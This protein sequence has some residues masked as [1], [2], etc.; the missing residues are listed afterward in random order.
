MGVPAIPYNSLKFGYFRLLEKRNLRKGDIRAFVGLRTWYNERERLEAGEN[1][2]AAHI[3]AFEEALS[4]TKEAIKENN[5]HERLDRDLKRWAREGGMLLRK[6]GGQTL[7]PPPIPEMKKWRGNGLTSISLFS[8]AFGLDLGFLAAGFDL[9]LANDI[10]INSYNTVTGN[11]GSIPFIHEDFT[12]VKIK[13]ALEIA[14]LD[15]GE[16][17]VLTGGPPCQ[18]FSTAGKREGLN[19]PRASPLKAFARAIKQIRPRA[20]V[21][22]EV[23]GLKSARLRHVPIKERKGRILTTEEQKG[24]A[25]KVVLQMLRATG[26]KLIFDVLNAADFGSPQSRMRLIFIGLRDGFPSLPVPTHSNQP[27]KNLEGKSVEAWNTFWQA[28]VDLQGGAKES[29]I[30]SETTKKYMRFIPPGGYWRHLPKD[31]IKEAMGGAFSSGGG[32]MGYFRRLSWDWPSPTV[33]TSPTQKGTM[34]GHPEAACPLSVEE[35]KR[36][37]GFPE[38]WRI[39]GKTSIKYRLIGDAVPVH[40]SYAIAKKVAHLLEA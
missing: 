20:F 21:M 14:G 28:T 5:V 29:A 36:I 27:Q 26:Y 35:Y 1:K 38:D 37:Q 34:F 7:L 32:K 8:G 10:D 11:I 18:P 23:T 24:S 31:L 19:D 4:E 25:F 39:I 9:K 3:A 33:V 2:Y 22:E 12:K 40:L 30:F 6:G 15:V 16:V 13:E 17:D